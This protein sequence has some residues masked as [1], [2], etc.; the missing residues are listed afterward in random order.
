RRIL[1]PPAVQA[2]PRGQPLQG[3]LGRRPAQPGEV[4]E[5]REAKA[6]G[7]DRR[8]VSATLRRPATRWCLASFDP[9]VDLLGGTHSGTKMREPGP[10]HGIAVGDDVSD[11]GVSIDH[12]REAY[13]QPNP[14]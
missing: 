14:G 10:V 2:L 11:G 8:N 9:C 5:L 6:G 3:T 1:L 4:V 13:R 7:V 12:G